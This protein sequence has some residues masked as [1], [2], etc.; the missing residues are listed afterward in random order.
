[1]AKEQFNKQ[2]MC[3][4]K[5]YPVLPIADAVEHRLIT[6]C[7]NLYGGGN[8][9]RGCIN[10]GNN[11]LS[12]FGKII[13]GI[14]LHRYFDYEATEKNYLES[15]GQSIGLLRPG[16][17]VVMIMDSCFSGT[18]TRNSLLSTYKK[19]RFI[20]PGTPEPEGRIKK[21]A[22][23][24]FMKWI[25]ISA[26]S[27]HQTASDAMIGNQYVGAFSYYAYKTLKQGMTWREWFNAIRLYLPSTD[28]E[29]IPTIEGPEFLLDRVIGHGQELIVHNSSHGSWIKDTS[30]DESDG[31]DEGLYLDKFISDDKI[32]VILQRIVL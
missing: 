4:K 21:V 17:T 23:T 12:T 8:D 19:S 10:D 2:V 25:A 5:K 31:R 15:L 3:F 6:T 9:L 1:M 16:A 13:P 28:F 14:A 7:R 20:D 27:E 30:G 22:R 32:N 18:A 26:A 29:Q 11:F 24:D